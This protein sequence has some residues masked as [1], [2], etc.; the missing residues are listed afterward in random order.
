MYEGYVGDEA[1]F[2]REA[3]STEATVYEPTETFH[4]VQLDEFV[5]ETKKEAK[6]LAR[7]STPKSKAARIAEIQANRKQEK[8]VIQQSNTEATLRERGFQP[9]REEVK[10]PEEEMDP[11]QRKIREALEKR[12]REE[13]SNP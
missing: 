12:L 10:E 8:D 7:G 5:E 6:R 3:D 13:E 2:V 1:A 9:A 11:I 4:R